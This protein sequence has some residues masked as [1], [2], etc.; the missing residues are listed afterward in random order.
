MVGCGVG[1]TSVPGLSLLLTGLLFSAFATMDATSAE[2]QQQ[3]ADRL[4]ARTLAGL[5][6]EAS[7]EAIVDI[8]DGLA[9]GGV[10]VLDVAVGNL[11][12]VHIDRLEQVLDSLDLAPTQRHV[13]RQAVLAVHRAAPTYRAL[14]DLKSKISTAVQRLC[15]QHPDLAAQALASASGARNSPDAPPE[16]AELH[17]LGDLYALLTAEI[18]QI[19][20]PAPAGT[21][22]LPPVAADSSAAT[23]VAYPTQPGLEATR[24]EIDA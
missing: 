2:A 15:A 23:E 18:A 17:A 3:P 11:H 4:N 12:I 7:E 24:V 14:A 19:F 5:L 22:A 10:A 16:L 6:P 13:L 9:A 21:A 1:Y 8:V 20:A